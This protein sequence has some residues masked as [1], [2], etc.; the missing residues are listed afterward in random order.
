MRRHGA[1]MAAPEDGGFEQELSLTF[2]SSAQF[3]AM[4]FALVW[5]SLLCFG[6]Q[7]L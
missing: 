7:G 4:L 3:R 5:V 2:F 6:R 1:D